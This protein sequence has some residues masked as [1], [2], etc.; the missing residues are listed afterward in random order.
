MMGKHT[1]TVGI[2][3]G[4]LDLVPAVPNISWCTGAQAE[5]VDVVLGPNARYFTLEMLKEPKY[6]DAMVKSVR[7]MKRGA[8]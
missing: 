3:A 7:K 5:E 8:K 6:V 2:P 4:W 1:V